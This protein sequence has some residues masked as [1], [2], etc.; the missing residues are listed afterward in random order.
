MTFSRVSQEG[1]L[2]LAI[3]A[4]DDGL[5]TSIKDTART[6]DVPYSTLRT[7]RNGIT[8]RS[9]TRLNCQKLFDLEDDMLVQ[10]ILDVD[11]RGYA[12][13]PENIRRKA[14]LLLAE[15]VFGTMATPPNCRDQLDHQICQTTPWTMFKVL[16]EI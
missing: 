10:W 9:E 5:I 6:Y 2:Q 7:R 1:R 15:R 4:L 16:S 14:N 13:R 3:K 11:S 12:P 8:A